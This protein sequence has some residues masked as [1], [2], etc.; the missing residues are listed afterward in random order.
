[1]KNRCYRI[2]C[3]SKAYCWVVNLQDIDPLEIKEAENFLDSDSRQRAQR[4][5]FEPDR[6][7]YLITHAFLRMKLSEFNGQS[8]SLMEFLRNQYGKPY[9]KN[10]PFYFNLSHTKTNAFLGIHLS[11]PIGVDIE[12]HRIS[13]LGAWCAEEAYLKAVGTGF[14]EGRAQLD[15]VGSSQTV[16]FFQK[17]DTE[18]RVYNDVLPECKLAV[19][20]VE[21]KD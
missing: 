8:P 6:T 18:I 3:V 13:N 16:D 20:V 15:W 2:E 4:F 5:V 12:N 11:C 1:M 10:N 17:D 7:R 14:L 19:C 21:N 9:L